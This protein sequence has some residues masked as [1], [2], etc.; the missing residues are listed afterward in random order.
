MSTGT[1]GFQVHASAAPGP[2][3]TRDRD[4]TGRTVQQLVELL[5]EIGRWATVRADR[6]SECYLAHVP[7]G[8]Q[9]FVVGKAEQYDFDLSREMGDLMCVLADRGQL[10]VPT[11]IP[12]STPEELENYFKSDAVIRIALG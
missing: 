1:L 9:L 8:L 2:R 7:D 3:S 5:S 4:R 11:L 10:V 12:A 6:V